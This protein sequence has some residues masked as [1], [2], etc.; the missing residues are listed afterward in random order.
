MLVKKIMKRNTTSGAGKLMIGKTLAELLDWKL[1]DQIA[2]ERPAMNYAGALVLTSITK[3]HVHN[4]QTAKL[5][6]PD[7]AI[8]VLHEFSADYQIGD[9]VTV[10]TDGERLYINKKKEDLK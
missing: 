2:I 8:T 7:Y 3:E 4:A 5:T 6:A 1:G 9:E 10:T